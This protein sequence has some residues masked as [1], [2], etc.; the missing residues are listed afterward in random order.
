LVLRQ[1]DHFGGLVLGSLDAELG[2]TVAL[3]DAI[4]HPRLGF[5]PD[6]LRGHLGRTQDGGHSLGRPG[7]AGRRLGSGRAGRLSG[8][9]AFF[10]HARSVEA[11]GRAERKIPT[12]GVAARG[13]LRSSP[14]VPNSWRAPQVTSSA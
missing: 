3:G 10:A 7:G 12:G 14:A 4:V 2:R 11:A 5:G 6:L 8:D 1:L 13:V 9:I